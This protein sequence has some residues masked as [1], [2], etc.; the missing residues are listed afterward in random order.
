MRNLRV[1][2]VLGIEFRIGW[3]VVVLFGLLTWEFA[4]PALPQIV[5][6]SSGAVYWGTAAVAGVAFIATLAAHELS[7]AVVARRRGIPVHDVTLWMLGG[8]AT[9]EGSPHTP[10]D[11]LAVALAGPSASLAIGV[12]GTAIG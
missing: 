5:P 3:S 8:V 4:V 1:G 2:R 9:I 7:H 11:E 12:V 6:G 10:R